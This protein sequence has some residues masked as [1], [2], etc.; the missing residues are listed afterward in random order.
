MLL[1]VISIVLVFVGAGLLKVLSDSSAVETGTSLV[2]V[3]FDGNQPLQY[4]VVS[5]QVDEAAEVLEQIQDMVVSDR[6][7]EAADVPQPHQ[8]DKN[9]DIGPS[10]VD[11][12]VVVDAYDEDEFETTTAAEPADGV[13][14]ENR[15]ENKLPLVTAVL[16]LV[17]AELW[18][19][20]QN[21]R[22]VQPS[23]VQERLAK[24]KAMAK[25]EAA[26]KREEVAKQEAMAR[27]VLDAHAIEQERQSKA[28]ADAELAQQAKALQ[29]SLETEQKAFEKIRR[30]EQQQ[31]QQQQQVA[32]QDR[33]RRQNQKR[34]QQE[35]ASRNKRKRWDEPKRRG[36]GG[37]GGG[38]R[39]GGGRG[40]HDNYGGRGGG[41]SGGRRGSRRH[42]E[43]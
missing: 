3:F 21:G 26:A 5:D 14:N 41:R 4:D 23:K 38:G 20:I 10:V 33:A 37:R 11:V 39:G 22:D 42:D 12:D 25:R 24:A 7:D 43:L 8:A 6:V 28:R 2:Q 18:E 19:V 1:I 36:G 29:N 15:P 13:E 30:R 31:Q 17:T 32:A 16:P 9:A 35:Q 34:Q 40:G 27:A